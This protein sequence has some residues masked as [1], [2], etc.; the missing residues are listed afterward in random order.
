MVSSRDH[1]DM[2]DWAKDLESGI[3]KFRYHERVFEL[4]YSPAASFRNNL[5]ISHSGNFLTI[6]SESEQNINII[7]LCSN[8]EKYDKETH[9]CK[10]CNHGYRSFG[11]QQQSCYS[12]SSLRSY[13]RQNGIE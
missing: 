12:C 2:I 13:G 7:T 6:K 3:S 8:Y 4:E 10:P 1:V 11:F 9:T 5:Y